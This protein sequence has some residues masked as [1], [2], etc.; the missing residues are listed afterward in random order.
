MPPLVYVYASVVRGSLHI[1][2]S[3][4]DEVAPSLCAVQCSAVQ[5][6][7][8]KCIIILASNW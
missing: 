7:Q 3:F 2:L 1:P 4:V 5:C 6:I 8:Y